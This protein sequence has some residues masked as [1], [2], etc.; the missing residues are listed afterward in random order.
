MKRATKQDK[1]TLRREAIK[2]ALKGLDS[3]ITTIEFIEDPAPP[4]AEGNTWG[5]VWLYRVGSGQ[6]PS[7]GE[8]IGAPRIETY[9]ASGTLTLSACLW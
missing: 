3:T 8:R 9:L 5:N 2:E 4:D 7:P 6:P 1:R